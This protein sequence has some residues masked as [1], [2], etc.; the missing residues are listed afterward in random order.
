SAVVK[1]IAPGDQ[2][3]AGGT[4]P[5]RIRA[6]HSWRGGPPRSDCVFVGGN[7]DLPGFRGL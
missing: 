5:E 1:F 3:G 7:P 4:L 2:S 6:V